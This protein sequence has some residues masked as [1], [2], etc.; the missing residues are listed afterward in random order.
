MDLGEKVERLREAWGLEPGSHSSNPGTA[1]TRPPRRPTLGNSLA[2]PS[3]W[4][5]VRWPGLACMSHCPM[6]TTTT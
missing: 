2:G 6:T 1:L 4:P 5:V 3:L